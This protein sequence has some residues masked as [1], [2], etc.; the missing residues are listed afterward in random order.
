MRA[1]V[2]QRERQPALREWYNGINAVNTAAAL[3]SA[4]P[5]K[6]VLP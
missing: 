4:G 5:F 6:L 1:P 2:S 3:Q